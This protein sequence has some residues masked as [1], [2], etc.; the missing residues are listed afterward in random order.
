MSPGSLLESGQ[1]ASHRSGL[2]GGA[3]G[4]QHLH[5]GDRLG[6]QDRPSLSRGPGGRPP[7]PDARRVLHPGDHPHLRQIGRARSRGG[8]EPLQGGRTSRSGRAGKED[9]PEV[10]SKS[11]AAA[12]ACRDRHPR[13]PRRTAPAIE[14]APAAEP[15]APPD[16]ERASPAV[17]FEEALKPRLSEAARKRIL[18]WTWRGLA[19]VLLVA[20]IIVVWPSRRHK[21]DAPQPGTTAAEAVVPPPPAAAP[22][23]TPSSAPGSET[24]TAPAAQAEP[25]PPEPSATDR[26]GPGRR[27][28][29]E[30]PHDRDHLPGRDLDPGPHGRRAQ[31]Q[32][33]FPPGSTA[34]AQ[35]DERLL[36]H[37]GNAGGFT[38]R[39]NGQPAKPLGRSGQ[40]LTDIR[41]TLEN[42]K[43]FLESPS[44]GLPT[45]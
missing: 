7:G 39:L 5:R 30:G 12:R 11:R 32:R 10:R 33:P 20:V 1:M 4:A 26:V 34:R 16:L 14:P 22:G 8:P 42:I 40:V 38:F 31:D 17:L 44:S 43:D 25:A 24:V 23:A 29:L 15:E 2:T 27:E 36:I 3:R 35:A 13:R 18:A 28:G 37:T 41:I 19:A 21:A 6:H 45:G 9:L